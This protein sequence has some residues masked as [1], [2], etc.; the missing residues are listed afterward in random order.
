ME[1]SD[2]L[3]NSAA[4]LGERNPIPTEQVGGWPPKPV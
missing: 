2:E 3:Y 1:A 4:F